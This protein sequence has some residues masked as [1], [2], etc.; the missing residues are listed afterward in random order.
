L[1][2]PSSA[3]ETQQQ[4]GGESITKLYESI[5]PNP[6]IVRMSMAEKGIDIARVGARPSVKA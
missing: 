1:A 3:V 2:K 5:G 4:H 6:R